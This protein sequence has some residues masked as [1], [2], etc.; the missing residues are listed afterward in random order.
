MKNILYVFICDPDLDPEISVN[1]GPKKN[2]KLI[3]QICMNFCI[4]NQSSCIVLY[5]QSVSDKLRCNVSY[6]LYMVSA[7]NFIVLIYK[8]TSF[9][10]TPQEFVFQLYYIQFFLSIRELKHVFIKPYQA[11][12]LSIRSKL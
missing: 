4:Y 7:Y 12:S 9:C 8:T 3:A 11:S 5:K 1:M 6:F 10:W 2:K